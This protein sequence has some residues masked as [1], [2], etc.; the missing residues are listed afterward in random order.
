[1]PD[2]EFDFDWK[3][4]DGI[5][6]PELASTLAA[7][8]IRVKDSVLTRVADHDDGLRVRNRIHAPLY[9][10]AEWLTENW[11]LLLHESDD[12]RADPSFLHR[13]ELG[14]SREGYGFPNVE[15][16]SFDART[17]ISWKHEPSQW[18][19]IEF[20][21]RAGAE[22]IDKDEFR[23]VCADFIDKVIR[24]LSSKGIEGTLLQ[25][26]WAAIQNTD[27]EERIFCATAAGLG[28]DPYAIDD[29]QRASVLCIGEVLHGAVFE[30]AVPILNAETLEADLAAIVRILEGGKTAGLPLERLASIRDAACRKIENEFPDRPWRIGYSLARAVRK[31]LGL[32]GAPLKSWTALSRALDEPRIGRGAATRPFSGAMR[33]DGVVTTDG[34]GQP[35]LAFRRGGRSTTLRFSFCRALAEFLL[36]PGTDALLTRTHSTRQQRGRAFAAEFLAPADGLRAGMR[37]NPL[38]EEDIEKLAVDFGV[39]PWVI[40]R[41]VRN[42][43]LANIQYDSAVRSAETEELAEAA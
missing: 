19:N 3:E 32:D 6:G 30:E 29:A 7:L 11:W 40:E 26:D 18:H 43:G 21:E 35:A 39:S 14:P 17:R 42:H 37:R 23:R 8:S 33:L 1:M 9:P 5:R 34:A 2:L 31:Q 13:H 38:D 24:R 4:I 12:R 20:L 36:S 16:V 41:Q 22:W 15:V 10:L 25:E 27:D 28:W